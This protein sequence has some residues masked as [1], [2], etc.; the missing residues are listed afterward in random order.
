MT[1]HFKHSDESKKS[2]EE[3]VKKF[4]INLDQNEIDIV[5]N[6][7]RCIKV[8]LENKAGKKFILSET[9]YR[10]FTQGESFNQCVDCTQQ[11]SDLYNRLELK[12]YELDV[13]KEKIKSLKKQIKDLSDSI[14]HHNLPSRSMSQEEIE[15]F[16]KTDEF[17][18]R[19]IVT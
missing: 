9:D 18:K 14:K 6:F 4:E 7:G 17:K 11:T 1:L 8:F 13:E 19:G 2:F 5:W 16:E 12:Q 15:K 3:F 10:N